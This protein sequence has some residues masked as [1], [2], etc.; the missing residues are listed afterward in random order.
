MTSDV[1]S[2]TCVLPEH[3]EGALRRGSQHLQ[4]L[5]AVAL[6]AIEIA[7]DPG[8]TLTDFTAIVERDM[9]LASDIL[10]MA[11]S[12]VFAGGRPLGSLHQA[13]L[14]L[15]LRQC[16]NLILSSSIA[17]AMQ[18]L[19]VREEWIREI[20]WRHGF[21][22][23]IVATHVNRHLRI[24]F[25]GEEFAAG[26]IHDFGRALFAT[27]LPE[28]F[29]ATDPLEFNETALILKHEERITGSN[30]CDVGAWFASLQKLPMEIVD[31]VRFHHS[32]EDSVADP[33]LTALIA[34]SDHLA[35]HLQRFDSAENYSVSSNAAAIVLED[36]G[37]KNA[38]GQLQ[39]D[40][41][42]ILSNTKRDSV[43]FMGV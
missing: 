35:N 26:L 22:T 10:S 40:A 42:E 18:K 15:G 37:V 1:I 12:A 23:G 25:Q 24:G 33:Q 7:R 5:P 19:T 34:V 4:M 38:V 14:R 21:V 11:N 32:P 2:L 8:A 36:S 3:I 16:G 31:V 30:H 43:E 39:N 29:A 6:Q 20:L 28:S 41:F 27:C 17:A 9:K 13:V